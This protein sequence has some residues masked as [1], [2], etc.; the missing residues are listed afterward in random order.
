MDEDATIRMS[1]A[2]ACQSRTE[3][4]R[5]KEFSSNSAQLDR[6]S[7]RKLLMVQMGKGRSTKGRKREVMTV[8]SISWGE[9]SPMIVDSL[10]PT[11]ESLSAYY[12][13]PS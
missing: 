12:F 4:G 7:L 3:M 8:K 10:R 6:T 11:F 2:F 9:I 5:V 13:Q 1:A